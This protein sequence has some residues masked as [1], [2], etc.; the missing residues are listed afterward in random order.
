M[1][2]KSIC[3]KIKLFFSKNK[4]NSN[5]SCFLKKKRHFNAFCSIFYFNEKDGMDF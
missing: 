5:M 1:D 4:L 2:H 3:F